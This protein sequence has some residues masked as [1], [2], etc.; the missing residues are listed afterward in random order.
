MIPGDSSG[1]LEFSFDVEPLNQSRLPQ[2]KNLNTAAQF[3]P[4]G[5]KMFYQL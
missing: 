4:Y 2:R 5:N 3:E 1:L